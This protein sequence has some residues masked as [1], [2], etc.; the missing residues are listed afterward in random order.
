MRGV[1]RMVLREGQRLKD[2]G[3]ACVLPSVACREMGADFV[4][5]SDVWELSW[6]LRSVGFE[7][8]HKRGK[9]VYPKHYQRALRHTDLLIAPPIP[10]AGYVPG[11]KAVELMIAAGEN[12][13]HQALQRLLAHPAA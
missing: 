13:T 10:R 8:T 11:K 6:L 1:R 2:G 7:P 12:A 9:L 4:I 5:G 3:I